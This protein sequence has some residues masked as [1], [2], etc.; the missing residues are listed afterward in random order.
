MCSSSGPKP[1]T[2]APPPTYEEA[3][4]RQTVGLT[5][6]V[7]QAA[8]AEQV[9]VTGADLARE[10]QDNNNE[11]IDGVSSE[12]TEDL[13]VQARGEILEPQITNTENIDIE[14]TEL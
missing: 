6:I 11:N 9:E 1:L 4:D 8:H 2:E 12:P 13:V 7:E 5:E 10:G 3:L 14:N